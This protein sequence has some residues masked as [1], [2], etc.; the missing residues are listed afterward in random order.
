MKIPTVSF[1]ALSG[2]GKTMIKSR[3]D[4]DEKFLLNGKEKI[5]KAGKKYSITT[6]YVGKEGESFSAYF[7][8]V[9]RN[10]AGQEIDRKIKWLNN[11]SEQ[12]TEINIVFKAEGKDCVPIYRINTETPI[13]SRCH[14]LL[15]PMKNVSIV[16]VDENIP[17][18][19]DD[20]IRYTSAPRTRELSI[21]EEPIIEKNMVWIFGFP[22]S[23]TTWLGTQLLS[24]ETKTINEPHI[25]DHLAFTTTEIEN[26][27]I[28]RID[29]M[30]DIPDYFFSGV[31]RTTWLNY[32]RKLI[33]NR[34]YSQVRDLDHKIIVK[35][36]SQ[37]AGFDLIS[38]CLPKSRIIVLLRDGRD[39]IDSALDARSENGFM[40]KA[41]QSPILG[42]RRLEFIEQISMSWNSVME[43]LLK[44][45]STHAK[46]LLYVIRYEDLRAN[47]FEELKK[48]YQ[49]LNIDID[50]K[51][52]K[53]IVTMNSFEAIPPEL[54]GKGKFARSAEPGRWDK[55]F[56]EKEKFVMEEKLGEMLKK[57]GYK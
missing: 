19:Y 44:V 48:I 8:V 34:F 2:V 9:L 42:D 54:R 39:V 10:K 1:T 41:G 26:E 17:E 12:N 7:G 28:R 56:N 32:L 43:N 30:K 27:N 50:N 36:P 51:K 52:L 3:L 55:N 11:F 33:L 31:Y 16:E 20:A 47:T 22:R 6:S 25:V 38:E 24:Y 4:S 35:E 21:D 23:G 57:L 18:I 5:I 53:E 46:E 37:L 49:F 14:F 13:V 40:V 29:E 45:T 15:L